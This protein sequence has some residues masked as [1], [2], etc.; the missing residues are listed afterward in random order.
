MSLVNRIAENGVERFELYS[1]TVQ[2]AYFNM[3]V[4]DWPHGYPVAMPKRLRVAA[5]YRFFS[6]NGLP[7]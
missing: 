7:L 2:V 5:C 3:K 1:F 6:V 4:D